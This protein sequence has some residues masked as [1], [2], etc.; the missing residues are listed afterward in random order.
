LVVAA[1]IPPEI[2]AFLV[3]QIIQG[4]LGN[5]LGTRN[6]WDG[7]EMFYRRMEMIDGGSD[8]EKENLTY[9]E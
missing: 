7:A 3:V 2:N 9:F 6:Q 8:A 4:S 5:P 1:V